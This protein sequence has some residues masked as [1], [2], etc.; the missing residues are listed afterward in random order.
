M[1]P[2]H[3][4][5]DTGALVALLDRSDVHHEWAV[6]CFRAMRPPLWTCEAVLTE[7]WHL[8]G[9]C[10]PSRDVLGDFCREGLIK[11][12]FC[13]GESMLR[14]LDLLK[15]YRDTPMD[16]ADACLVRMTEDQTDC[17]V[18]TVDSDAKVYRRFG[19][20][21]IPVLAPW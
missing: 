11:I 6:D 2:T 10:P 21:T 3:W 9:W 20:R 13:L 5:A 18:W 12:D 4:I 15:K 16:F 1:T 17:R 19:R 7:V 14:V 8:L